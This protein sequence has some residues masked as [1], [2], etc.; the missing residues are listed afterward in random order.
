MYHGSYVTDL[1]HM[2]RFS[3]LGQACWYWINVNCIFFKCNYCW[4]NGSNLISD[5]LRCIVWKGGMLT[6]FT[7]WIKIS[8]SK[9]DYLQHENDILDVYCNCPYP[10]LFEGIT[11][12]DKM[13]N[14]ICEKAPFFSLFISCSN[15]LK[16][17]WLILIYV[18]SLVLTM[19]SHIIPN[20]ICYDG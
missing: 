9:Y 6:I 14:F 15:D 18:M 2:I 3:I 1:F 19:I 7:F 10:A 5:M 12:H 17:R 11:D 20:L 4:Q 8:F 13:T 16:I